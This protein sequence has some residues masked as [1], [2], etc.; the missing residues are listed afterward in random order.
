MSQESE[1]R[2]HGLD[3]LRGIAMILGIVLHAALPYV[4]KD[5]GTFWPQD[6]DSSV[7]IAT[8]NDFIHAW[9]MPTFFILSGFFTHLVIKRKS[10]Q[11]WYQNRVI[12]IL[13][14]L[15]IFSPIMAFTIPAIFLY[16]FVLSTTGKIWLQFFFGWGEYPFHLWF[17]W[18]LLTFAI[19]MFCIELINKILYNFCSII[20]LNML[21]NKMRKLKTSTGKI[22]FDS[23]LP[24]PIIILLSFAGI[25][26]GGEL[27]ENPL[28]SS[29]FFALGYRLYVNQ[30]LLQ[31]MDAHWIY[32]CSL[33]IV[34]FI[35]LLFIRG[36][37]GDFTDEDSRWIMYILFVTSTNILLSYG[38]IGLFMN[39]CSEYNKYLKFIADSSYWIYLVHLPIVTFITFA[40]FQINVFAEI[41]FILA[42]FLTSTICLATYKLFV[43]STIMGLLLNGKTYP[44]RN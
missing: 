10:W 43:R 36:I 22:F 28:A 3:A 40:M 37:S 25:W 32:Y 34:A 33:G 12:R 11:Y 6:N 7:A 29:L 2:H 27:I 30:K 20:R 21:I 35:C 42:I 9:R 19:G 39:K 5:Y 41:K 31:S 38:I 18:H 23:S 4:G 14:P 13:L 17:L 44:F 1:I 15:I 16:G 24:A 8:I 26:T